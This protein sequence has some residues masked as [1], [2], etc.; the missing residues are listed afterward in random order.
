MNLSQKN[1][2]NV[3]YSFTLLLNL[4]QNKVVT[5]GSKF[6][7][8]QYSITIQKVSIYLSKISDN[9]NKF[10]ISQKYIK[11]SNYYNPSIM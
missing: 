7:S 4:L 5:H 6:K 2:K 3:L 11:V 1:Y 10:L 9:I 8:I